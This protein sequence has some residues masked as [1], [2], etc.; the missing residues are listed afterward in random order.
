VTL[1]T[2]RTIEQGVAKEHGKS[3]AEYTEAVAVCFMSTEDMKGLGIKSGQHVL[4]S[5]EFGSVI[6]KA[7]KSPRTS[8]ERVVLIPYG[9]WANAVVDPS[10]NGIGMPSLK[11]IP[12]KIKP[13][14][15]GPLSL[16]ELLETQFGKEKHA[17]H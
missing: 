17:D 15:R 6:V 7:L 2:G 9:P 8:H 10:T 5:T 11:G 13:S 3:S 1:L 4:V 14:S 16:E 12:A